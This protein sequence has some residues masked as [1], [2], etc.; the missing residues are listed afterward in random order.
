M[1]SPSGLDQ[2]RVPVLDVDPDELSAQLRLSLLTPIA[3]TRLLLP[4][5]RERGDGA[6]LFASGISATTPTPQLGNI[7]VAFAGL[8]NYVG[9]VNLE[10]AGDGVYAGVVHIGGLIRRSAVERLF[11]T[12][13]ASDEFADFDVEALKHAIIEPDD[14]DDLFWD[15]QLK[16]DRVEETILAGG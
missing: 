14:I 4:G 7:G 15:L 5:M 16:R 3:L 13:A 2:Q 12:S 8:R 11:A 10:V 1:Y 6:L 9:S